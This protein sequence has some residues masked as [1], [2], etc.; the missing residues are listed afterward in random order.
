M[1]TQTDY[2]ALIHSCY[3]VY[4]LLLVH[5]V[6]PLIL[7]LLDVTRQMRLCRVATGPSRFPSSLVQR[8]A[9]LYFRYQIF[10]LLDE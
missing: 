9:S 4:T 5:I 2:R 10:P 8:F 1:T 3:Q 6:S 7:D